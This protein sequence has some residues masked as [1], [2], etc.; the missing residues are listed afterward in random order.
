M[1]IKV[2][3]LSDETIDKLDVLAK[4]KG[5][6]REEFLYKF[7]M[8]ISNQENIFN[9]FSRYEKLLNMIENCLNENTKVLNKSKELH[10][11]N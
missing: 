3:N 11:E 8:N 10:R 4:K 2:T 5:L 9:V 7:I 6:S 1:E